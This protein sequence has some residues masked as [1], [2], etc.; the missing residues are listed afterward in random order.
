[1]KKKKISINI[2]VYGSVLL[3]PRCNVLAYNVAICLLL[4]RIDRVFA[5]WA[6]AHVKG[7]FERAVLPAGRG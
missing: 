2:F 1:M 7:H 5:A 4:Q 6:A 3:A